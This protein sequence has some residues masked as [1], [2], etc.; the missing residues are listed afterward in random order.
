M[1]D[2][3]EDKSCPFTSLQ[4]AIAVTMVNE[5]T[6]QFSK[7]DS[8][9]KGK[10]VE[11]IEKGFKFKNVPKRFFREYARL[12]LSKEYLQNLSEPDKKEVKRILELGGYTELLKDIK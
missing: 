3:E 11:D 7:T 8:K 4:I 2:G 10:F 1:E 5:K 9:I 12:Q 6:G